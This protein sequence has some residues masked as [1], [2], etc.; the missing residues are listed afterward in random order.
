MAKPRSIYDHNP[1]WRR[2]A[3]R[4]R[5]SLSRRGRSGGG[6]RLEPPYIVMIA[7]IAAILLLLALPFFRPGGAADNLLSGTATSTAAAPY[8][9]RFAL[10]GSGPRI[11]CVVDGDTFW[12]GGE[13]VRIADIDTPELHPA[14]CTEEERLGT[15]AK[16]RL[17][18][19]LNA[20]PF[21]LD[22]DGTDRYGRTLAIVS[23]DGRSLGMML[24]SEGL[25][26]RYAGG[27]RSGWCG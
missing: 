13:K 7:L 27:R 18:E 15:A 16:L 14:R 19:L 10:C 23:R 2:H 21:A 25:A 6:D 20:A 22:R 9:T 1:R 12:I 24:V 4:K 17:Q 3:P 26:R 5:R 11:D 8:S